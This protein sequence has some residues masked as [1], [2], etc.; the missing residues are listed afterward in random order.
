MKN[1]SGAVAGAGAAKKFSGSPA[2]ESIVYQGGES[3]NTAGSLQQ[4]NF[5]SNAVESEPAVL[6]EMT[7][8]PVYTLFFPFSFW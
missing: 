3:L 8:P 5:H 6:K 7:P 4:L 1:K 2:L